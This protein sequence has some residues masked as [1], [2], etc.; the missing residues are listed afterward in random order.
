MVCSS[1]KDGT[2]TGAE[3]HSGLGVDEHGDSVHCHAQVFPV[4]EV[5]TVISEHVAV[6]TR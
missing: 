1:V 2:E 6:D 5:H 4:S 3:T